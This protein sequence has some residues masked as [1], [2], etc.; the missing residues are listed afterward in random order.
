MHTNPEVLA[1]SA[2][3]EWTGNE[4]EAQHLG[5]CPECRAELEELNYVVALGRDVV[6]AF[7]E[8]P[9]P[10]VWDRV[11]A[12]LGL[13]EP[14]GSVAPLRPAPGAPVEPAQPKD[15]VEPRRR[16]VARANLAGLPAW[17]MSSGWASVDVD[18]HGD[19]KIEV[20]LNG[21][22]VSDALTE[23]WLIKPDLSGMVSLGLMG[24]S[25]SRFDLPALIDLSEYSLVD[26]S[27]EP[28]DGSTTH[29][30]DSI[31]RGSLV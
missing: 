4:D 6:P 15:D 1:M 19:R 16:V 12:E 27:R 29:S 5:Q 21:P 11:A 28:L 9:A 2:L 8:H 13:S 3:G 26:V 17:P 22:S 10:R 25:R 30:G 7:L 20:T 31:L 23:A 14:L 24:G 18:H